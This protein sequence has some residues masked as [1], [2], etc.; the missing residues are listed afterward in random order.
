M[1]CKSGWPQ[2]DIK[3][4]VAIIV[5]IFLLAV[6]LEIACS[7]ARGEEDGIW[8]FYNK[9]HLSVGKFLQ[10]AGKDIQA[11]VDHV[12]QYKDIDV[13]KAR[14]VGGRN[15]EQKYEINFIVVYYNEEM[16]K[17]KH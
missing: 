15:L 11:R 16:G 2:V 17:E 6:F 13:Y 4:F 14:I 12:G 3:I 8:I 10:Q 1:S 9:E 7:P 5:A